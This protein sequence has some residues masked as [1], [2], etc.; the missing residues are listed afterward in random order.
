MKFRSLLAIGC[1]CSLSLAF[2]SSCD[3]KSEANKEQ[4][5]NARQEAAE[6]T[7]GFNPNENPLAAPQK[8]ENKTV[9][10]MTE[11]DEKVVMDTQPV[12]DIIV[13]EDSVPSKK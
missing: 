10:E 11:P 8:T 5:E 9:Q 2:F 4:I 6:M 1:V 3:K 12:T 7:K 13:T